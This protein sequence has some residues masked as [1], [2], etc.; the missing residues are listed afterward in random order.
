MTSS[1]NFVNRTLWTGDNLEIM[2]G[3]NSGCVDMIY[4]D[5]PFNS[6][7]NYAAPIGSEAAGAAFKDAWTLSDVDLAW[8]GEIAEREPSLYAALDS[9]GIVHGK[10]MKSYL[11][12]MAIRLLEMTRILK[13]A[14][15]LWLH[16][17]QDAGHYL[18]MLLDAILGRQNFVT[19]VI[20]NYGTPSG[21]RVGGRKPVKVHDCLFL[22][23]ADHGRHVY[24]RQ[25]V[26]YSEKYVKD[27]FRHRDEDG[28]TYRTRSRK[29]RIVRQYLDENP[30]VPLSTV[31]SDIMQLSSRRG[32]F[33]TT[34][35]EET[36]YPTQKPLALLRRIIEAS[37]NRGDMVLDP[38]CGCATT[39]VAAEDLGRRWAGVDLSDVAARLV[40]QR[41]DES[42]TLS[43]RG[44]VHRT[45]I[46]LRTDQGTLPSYR[47]HK[48]TLFG[49]QEGRCAGCGTVFQFRNMAVDHVV[50]KSRGGTDHIENLQLLCP[51]CNSMKGALPQAEFIANLKRK[52]IR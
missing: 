12:M 50:P 20:W 33:P 27:W 31:W 32:W 19:E 21:G 35:R 38:F 46:P 52:G 16:C 34:R 40:R 1:S 2:R 49:R 15:S 37:S 26:P 22:Y 44:V 23:A 47:S 10:G 24:N 30:G 8:H 51:A 36:G 18:K 7:R 13:P 43:G 42:E 41:L 48:H 17:N 11:I 4:L 45:D 28:R 3:M 25:H 9:A 29:G 39:L 14:G 5:P 6:N